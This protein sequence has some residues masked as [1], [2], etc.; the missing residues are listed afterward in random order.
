[1]D[2]L[3]K[4]IINNIRIPIWLYDA[5]GSLLAVNKAV[6]ALANMTE[7]QILASECDKVFCHTACRQ[8]NC[9]VMECLKTRKSCSRNFVIF[10][11][12]CD[13]N[14]DPLFDEDGNLT[15]V[16]KS[17][18]DITDL[19]AAKNEEK[20]QRI[21]LRAIVDNAQIAVVLKDPNDEFR[22]L[23]CNKY[24]CDF[25]GKSE[26]ELIGKKDTDLMQNQNWRNEFDRQDRL[27][28]K[29]AS[30]MHFTDDIILADDRRIVIDKFKLP[31]KQGKKTV[32]LAVFIDVTEIVLRYE[33]ALVSVAFRN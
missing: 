14:A 15:N 18:N 26:A 12:T 1:M 4:K 7:E 20:N 16:I 25:F 22:Y 3:A 2:N 30:P 31:I 10:G 29:S 6:C 17:A 24:F 19:L 32:L 8:T 27:A 21:L 33:S 13:I 23:M 11:R 5:K 9:P 28:I